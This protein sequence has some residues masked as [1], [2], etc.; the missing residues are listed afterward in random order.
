[1]TPPLLADLGAAVP[2]V[3]STMAEHEHVRSKIRAGEPLTDGDRAVIDRR[4]AELAATPREARPLAPE[5][6]ALLDLTDDEL[7]E[8][9]A[10]CAER[11]EALPKYW[12]D[13]I[14]EIGTSSARHRSGP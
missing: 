11:F 3:T 13:T 4:L 10:R 2:E 8:K 12:R 1:M 9:V 5:A 6:Q 14:D 7:E